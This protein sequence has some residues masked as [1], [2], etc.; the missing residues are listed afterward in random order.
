VALHA[1]VCGHEG[2]A[3]VQAGS[4][5]CAAAMGLGC[6][7]SMPV[8]VRV[9]MGLGACFGVGGAMRAVT[10][11]SLASP[12]PVPGNGARAGGCSS[13]SC[14]MR[15]RVSRVRLAA[16]FCQGGGFCKAAG[17]WKDTASVRL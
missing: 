2:R 16:R 14:R 13:G 5:P 11:Q 8:I 7:S 10:A 3:Y 9:E 15:A 4:G 12:C 1:D 17:L 6:I